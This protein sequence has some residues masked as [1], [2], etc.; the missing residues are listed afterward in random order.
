MASDR[1]DP[2]GG[3]DRPMT[4]ASVAAPVGPTTMSDT[5]VASPIRRVNGT[6]NGHTLEQTLTGLDALDAL[7]AADVRTRDRWRRRAWRATW[8]KLAALALILLVWQIAVWTHFRPTILQ[9][10]ADVARQL[11]HLAGTSSFWQS[12]EITAEQALFG[13]LLV[14]VVGVVIGTAVARIPVLRAAIG[15][16]LTGMQTLPS[17]LWYPVAYMVWGQNWRSV[18]LMMVLGAVPA[19]AN[20]VISGIDLVPPGLLRAGR[21]LG[22]RGLALE[23]HVVLPA[24]F[25]SIVGGLKQAWAFAWH[26]LMAGEFLIVVFPLSLGARTVNALTQAEFDVVVALM[27]VIVLV[28]ILVDTGFSR[29]NLAV[30][31]RYG[32]LDSAS[33]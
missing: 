2:T 21:V 24:A 23:R 1:I 5:S 14:V 12:C 27:V 16:L 9:S 4:A 25:P 7:D 17:V 31:R 13:Y 10:P 20:G 30:R 33:G 6:G 15:S 19:A 3:T 32:L 11:W 26:A 28:G 8:P 29:L 22:A 18:I